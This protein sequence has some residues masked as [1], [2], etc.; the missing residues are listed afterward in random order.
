M[1]GFNISTSLSSR[2][3]F[4]SLSN[5]GITLT[6]LSSKLILIHKVGIGSCTSGR[7]IFQKQKEI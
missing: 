1:L 4:T 2:Y 3:S 7:Y 5:I 6:D